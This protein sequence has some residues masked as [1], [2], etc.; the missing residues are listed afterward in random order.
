MA[1]TGKA[2]IFNL[3]VEIEGSSTS[4]S[5]AMVDRNDITE[6]E[7]C[8][9]WEQKGAN[10][11][12]VFVP[13]E[14]F[15]SHVQI[16]PSQ[17]LEAALYLLGLTVSRC[18][19]GVCQRC[20]DVEEVFP[21][22]WISVR[23]NSSHLTDTVTVSRAAQSQNVDGGIVTSSICEIA[24]FGSEKFPFSFLKTKRIR[25]NFFYTSIQV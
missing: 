10:D 4:K 21:A 12:T 13:K 18:Y 22:K 3:A 16:L 19:R 5:A 14:Q 23:C 9:E 6:P 15:V 7:H 8:F 24:L 1:P 11:V 20:G 2:V 17:D 25:F